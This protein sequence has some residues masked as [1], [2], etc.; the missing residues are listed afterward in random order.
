MK[1]TLMP[2]GKSVRAAIVA[3]LVLGVVFLWLGVDWT[4]WQRWLEWPEDPG[5]WS[6]ALYQPS[7]A[8]QGGNGP[9]FPAAA[10]S[11][12]TI[13]AAVLDEAAEYAQEHNSVALLVLHR[14]QV[15][16]ERYWQGLDSETL[17]SVRAMTRS[18]LGPLVG[19]AL[20]EGALKSL[21]EPVANYL[22]EWAE[23]PRGAITIRQMLW[24]VSGLESPPLGGGGPFSKNTRIFWGSD[25]AAGA[26]DFQ[27]EREPGTFFAISNANAQLLGLILERATGQAYEAYLDAKLWT[28]LGAGNAEMYMDREGGMP[29][30]YCCYRVLPRDWLRLGAAFASDGVVSGQRIWPEGW[31]QEISRTSSA[32]PNYGYQVWVGNPPGESRPYVQGSATGFPHGPPIAADDVLFFEGGGYRTLYIIPSEQLVILRLGYADQNWQTS[33]LPNILLSGLASGA[34]AAPTVPPT[35]N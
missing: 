7:A 8:I 2:N 6:A 25:F 34:E 31:L 11:E 30:V 4:L 26:L 3:V 19:I 32:N 29:S 5:E 24:N 12:L 10:S 9:F 14:G 27:L 16:L 15:L 35:G 17:F 22:T 33:A 20:A 23:D 1:V 18:M 28:P 13:P 21:D